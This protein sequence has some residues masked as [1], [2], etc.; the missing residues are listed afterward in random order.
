MRISLLL[1]PILVLCMV[2]KIKAQELSD[3]DILMKQAFAEKKYA[4]RQVNYMFHDAG[5]VKKYNPFS[6]F[7][8]GLLYVYQKAISPQISVDCPYEINC[9]SFSRRCIHRY[10]LV[11]GIMLTA[12]RLTRCTQFT[13]IDLKPHNFK[14]NF[15]II[16]PIEKYTFKSTP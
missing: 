8:G 15:K 10:G 11:K 13:M 7:F 5:M 12:D 4:P 14:D 9:S 3:K 1:I 16:D 6:L 2:L